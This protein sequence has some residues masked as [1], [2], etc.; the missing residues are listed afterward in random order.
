MKHN[1]GYKLMFSQ[2]LRKV[3]VKRRGKKGRGEEGDEEEH[4]TSRLDL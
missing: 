4:F 1:G 3:E 2:T